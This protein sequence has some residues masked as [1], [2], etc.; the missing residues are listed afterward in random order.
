MVLRIVETYQCRAQSLGAAAEG[1]L[2]YYR[3][4]KR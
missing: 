4:T 1:K 3:V 2:Q